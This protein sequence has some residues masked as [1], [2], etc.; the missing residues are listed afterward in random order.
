LGID[1]CVLYPV[2]RLEVIGLMGRRIPAEKHHAVA[3]SI[4][5]RATRTLRRFG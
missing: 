1:D 5:T 3:I 4:V 2:L